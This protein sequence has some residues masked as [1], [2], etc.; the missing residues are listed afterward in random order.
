MDWMYFPPMFSLLWLDCISPT[1]STYV[2]LVFAF[3]PLAILLAMFFFSFRPLNTPSGSFECG[4]LNKKKLDLDPNPG[5][6]HLGLVLLFMVFEVEVLVL[7]PL[8]IDF[9]LEATTYVQ[10][11]GIIFVLIITLVVELSEDR[12]DSKDRFL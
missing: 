4:V 8:L 9:D 3:I 12:L 7:L 6:E 10:C 5:G 2:F 11:S 1:C